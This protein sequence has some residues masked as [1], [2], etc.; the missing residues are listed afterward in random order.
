M[1]E[2]LQN[3][4]VPE[5]LFL[6]SILNYLKGIF[7]IELSFVVPFLVEKVHTL[8]ELRQSEDQTVLLVRDAVGLIVFRIKS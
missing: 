4:K 3:V 7:E 8:L 1:S 5:R 2:L 6:L